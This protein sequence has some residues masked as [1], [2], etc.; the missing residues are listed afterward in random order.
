MLR[1]IHHN[2]DT[3]KN[4][5]TFSSDMKRVIIALTALLLILSACN[6]EDN[7]NTPVS[8]TVFVG[9]SQG[10]VAEFEPFGVEENGVFTVFDTESFPIEVTL[11]NEGEDDVNPGDITVTLKGIN[12][13]DFNGI[14]SSELKN[15]ETLEKVAEFNPEG[16]EEIVDFTPDQDAKYKLNV[17]GFFQ[18]D[19]YAQVDYNYTTYI[20]I[21]AVCYKEDPRDDSV[22]DVQG[23]K[24][25]AV[26]S[27]P[28][29]VSSVKQDIAGRGIIVLT[30]TVD[31]VGAGR[32]A[33]PSEDFNPSYGKVLVTME[34]DASEW[35]CRSSGNPNEARLADGKAVITCKLRQPL[36]EDTLFTKQVDLRLDYRYRSIIQQAIRI[37]ESTD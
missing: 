25:F 8:D 7:T 37:R 16:D 35:E 3:F 2:S 20:V 33:L 31:N 36:T 4:S 17:T 13:N 24:T 14:P 11:N 6:G 29:T 28:I 5:I 26:S 32:V 30:I 21:P 9:G 1:I 12:T 23:S 10:I 27:A 15:T 19:I 34:T 18:P 22:C